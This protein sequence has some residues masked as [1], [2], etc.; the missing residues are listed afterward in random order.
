MQMT[1]SSSL[2]SVFCRGRP[3]VRQHPLCR[4]F[5]LLLEFR[6]LPAHVNMVVK[7]ALLHRT[8]RSKYSY[9]STHWTSKE[10]LQGFGGLIRAP[11]RLAVALRQRG[12]AAFQ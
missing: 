2:T 5:Q 12:N 6:D 8:I 9:T 4:G 1:N 7:M 3:A 11:Y 10:L